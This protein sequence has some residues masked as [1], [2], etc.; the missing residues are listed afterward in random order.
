MITKEQKEQILAI[1][2]KYSSLHDQLTNLTQE[3]AL[4]ELRRSQLSQELDDTRKLEKELI[5]NIE[6][7]TGQKVDQT[8]I[9]KIIN[10]DVQ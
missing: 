5:N 10:E 6:Q 3:A 9:L 4:L 8:T 2:Q 1:H 7:Y